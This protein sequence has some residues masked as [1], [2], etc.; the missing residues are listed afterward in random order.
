MNDN[1][2][3]SCLLVRHGPEPGIDPVLLISWEGEQVRGAQALDTLT[4]VVLGG[5]AC[6]LMPSGERF[7]EDPAVG[8][9]AM[10]RKEREL[11]S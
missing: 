7:G 4:S 9:S 10:Q 3:G 11:E 2:H 8:G 1:G 5:L 6:W